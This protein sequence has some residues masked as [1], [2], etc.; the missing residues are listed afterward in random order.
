MGD[1]IG[2][3]TPASIQV[4]SFPAYFQQ[5]RKDRYGDYILT[6][7]VAK[8]DK[9]TAWTLTDYDGMMLEVTI[10]VIPRIKT[11]S[12]ETAIDLTNNEWETS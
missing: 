12:I 1:V 10:R 5:L 2:P 11:A 3:A 8:A 9:D 4:T 7:G 6:L